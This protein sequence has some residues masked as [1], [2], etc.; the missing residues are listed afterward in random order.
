MKYQFDDLLKNKWWREEDRMH[1]IIK[2]KIFR[3][4]I[5]ANASFLKDM[6]T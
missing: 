2:I 3:Y 6:N 1:Y 4:F 5:F